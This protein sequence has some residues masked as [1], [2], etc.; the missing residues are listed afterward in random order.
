[1]GRSARAITVVVPLLPV[2]KSMGT[3]PESMSPSWWKRYSLDEVRQLS[4]WRLNSLEDS[5]FAS[6]ASATGTEKP[7]RGQKRASPEP[8]VAEN[9]SSLG[10]ILFDDLHRRRSIKQRF[11]PAPNY[12]SAATKPPLGKPRKMCTV[13]ADLAV[14]VD[15]KTRLAFKTIEASKQMRDSP[16]A[17]VRAGNVPYFDALRHIEALQ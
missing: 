9:I 7:K 1:M 4:E 2:V 13:A 6:T 5:N 17:W 15:A 14:Y 10:E 11:A 16:P 12:A 3:K 8:E